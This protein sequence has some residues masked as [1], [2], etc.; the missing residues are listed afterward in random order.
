MKFYI[1]RNGV[2]EEIPASERRSH[3][4]FFAAG[5]RRIL[6]SRVKFFSGKYADDTRIK[7]I[8][9][10]LKIVKKDSQR[11]NSFYG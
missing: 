10:L 1:M 8:E 9:K 11:K 5:S 3:A 7:R 6:N 4:T 2:W